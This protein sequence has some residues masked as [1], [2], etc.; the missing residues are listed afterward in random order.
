ME[1]HR[2]FRTDPGQNRC[3]LGKFFIFY[4][5]CSSAASD[6]RSCRGFKSRHAPSFFINIRLSRPARQ[7]SGCAQTRAHFDREPVKG[8]EAISGGPPR[9]TRPEPKNI[10]ECNDGI[11]PF[12]ILFIPQ[13]ANEIGRRGPERLNDDRDRKQDAPSLAPR[14][15]EV[16]PTRSGR[17]TG[18]ARS[19]PPA[20]QH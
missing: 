11:I 6:T 13:T 18:P 2:A 16:S 1:I 20:R 9:L 3:G 4:A 7:S 12:D 8:R 5:Y 17:R 10:R 14:Q 19:W 15:T